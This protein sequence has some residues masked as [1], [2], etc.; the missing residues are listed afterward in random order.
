M[1]STLCRTPLFDAHIRAGAKMAGFAGY[2]M[3]IQYT[4]IIAEAK[5]VR[6]GAGMF[7]VSHMA[8][9]SLTGDR[10]LEYLEWITTNDVSKLTD[11]TGQYSLLPN[12]QGGAVDDIIVYRIHATNFR[13]VVNASNHIK[14][15]AWMK[16]QN[17][18]GVTIED[19]TDE[20]AMIAVQGPKAVAILASM[21][22]DGGAFESAPA[23]GIVNSTVAEI[24]VF[25]ARSGYTGEDGYEL[26]C[27]A[28][29]ADKLWTALKDHGVV[30]C[31]LGSRDV[32]RVEAGLPLY[33]HE[34]DDE[35]SPLEAGLGWVI[36]KTKTFIGSEP[37]AQVRAQGVESKLMGV[38]LN[39]KRLPMQG[40]QIFSGDHAVG[41]VSSGIYSPL[42]ECGVAFAFLHPSCKEGD[43]VEIDMRGK[44]EPAVV[45]NKRFYKRQK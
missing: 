39:G 24:P 21:S 33:G 28:R 2:D 40:A 8:R 16:L 13:M 44:K 30:E 11:G 15:L 1:E 38:R 34:L 27:A 19:L 31:G 6:E 41:G 9:L 37:M 20:T 4:G 5:A 26:I 17:S 45:V 22:P 43:A 7:D 35:R 12:D 42:L 3:P 18:F 32:L 14:D 10:V 29:D 36:S 23:F 25:A